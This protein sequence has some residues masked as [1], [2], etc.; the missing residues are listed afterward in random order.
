LRE[1]LSPE[2]AFR[3]DR[4][5]LKLIEPDKLAYAILHCETRKVDKSGWSIFMNQKYEVDLSFIGRQVDVVFDHSD[6]EEL[7][8]EYEEY[9]I[10][11]DKHGN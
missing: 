10:R 6:L 7:T 11:L 8:L 1:K 3:S 9:S 2:S 5:P 4:K